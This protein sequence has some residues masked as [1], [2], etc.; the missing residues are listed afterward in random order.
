MQRW[1]ER[2]IEKP[3]LRR[4]QFDQLKDMYET[5]DFFIPSP[6]EPNI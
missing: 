2:L 3:A 6:F 5:G 1:V 4:H